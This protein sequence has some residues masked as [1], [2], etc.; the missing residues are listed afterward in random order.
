MTLDDLKL[1]DFDTCSFTRNK[2][3]RQ[4]IIYRKKP[5]TFTDY[6]FFFYKH[7]VY[8]HIEAEKD[9]KFKHMASIC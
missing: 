4:E 8:K 5:D 3:G 7:N 9:Q 6:M 1:C 2:Y